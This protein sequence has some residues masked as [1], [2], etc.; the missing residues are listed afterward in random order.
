[1]L[2]TKWFTENT[3]AG[4]YF[5]VVRDTLKVTVYYPHVHTVVVKQ[6][7]SL[8]APN[9][10]PEISVSPVSA[11]GGRYN[12]QISGYYELTVISAQQP[13]YEDAAVAPQL[14]RGGNVA[15]YPDGE[16]DGTPRWHIIF[17][18]TPNLSG[19][20]DWNVGVSDGGLLY[21]VKLRVA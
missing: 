14:P 8:F 20:Q 2:G 19:F 21:L 10:A 18:I 11:T 7:H 9:L 13:Y 1:V 3:C 4:T 16:V 15:L 12:V 17:H 6:G 5:R